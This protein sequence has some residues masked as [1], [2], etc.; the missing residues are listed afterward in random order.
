MKKL[1]TAIIVLLVLLLIALGYFF[2]PVDKILGN[3]PLLKELYNNTSIIVN[4]RNGKA[5]VIINGKNYG[6][7][8]VELSGLQEGQYDI[9][10]KRVSENVDFYK[11]RNYKIDLPRNTQA[12]IDLEIGPAD[13]TS[14]YILYYTQ[15][16]ATD[17]SGYITI[18]NTPEDASVF[19]DGEF[20]AKTPINAY[21]LKEKDYQVKISATGYEDLTFPIVVREGYNL[22]V[23]S[24]L[25][26]VPI[27]IEE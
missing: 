25:F 9:V 22:N 27:N 16:P 12:I 24:Y 2:I 3:L 6:E 26:P 13:A 23:R 20:L 8:K 19:L 17:G 1:K 4:S 14:G 7:T 5:E 11:T 21:T 18:Q 10:L 15:S